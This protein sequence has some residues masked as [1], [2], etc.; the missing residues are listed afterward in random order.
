MRAALVLTRRAPRALQPPQIYT[1]RA[2]DGTSGW[3]YSGVLCAADDA[4]GAAAAA[5]AI[6]GAHALSFAHFAL[7]FSHFLTLQPPRVVTSAM[8]E[9]PLLVP[10][11]PAAPSG[12]VSHAFF[13]VSPDRPTNRVIYWVGPYAASR[14]DLAR[15]HG[16]HTLDSGDVAYAPNILRDNGGAEGGGAPRALLFAWLQER[17]AARVRAHA[18]DHPAKAPADAAA[19]CDTALLRDDAQRC[20]M[21]MLCADASLLR[22]RTQF[23]GVAYASVA[24]AAA[25]LEVAAHEGYSG[26]APFS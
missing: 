11:S 22:R 20:A 5:G 24:E 14:F 6:G 10:L 8:W 23:G 7:L 17:D 12:A 2:A 3:A 16:P 26:C 4:A 15:A 21:I 18:A 13:C 19:G 25:A 9:C 1:S